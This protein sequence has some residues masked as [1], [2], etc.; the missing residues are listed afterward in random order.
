MKRRQ[1]STIDSGKDPYAIS[2]VVSVMTKNFLPF[3][4]LRYFQMVMSFLTKFSI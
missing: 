2:N 3:L 4:V 1:G